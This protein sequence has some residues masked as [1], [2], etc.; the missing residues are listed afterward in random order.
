[1]KT[2]IKLMR[3]LE[4]RGLSFT[5][6]VILNGCGKPVTKMKKIVALL[7]AGHSVYHAP[8]ETCALVIDGE[9][10][11]LGALDTMVVTKAEGRG[12]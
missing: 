8:F 12:E 10:T 9:F 4:K 6:N 3:E 2:K 1:M 5:A 7:D 11:W